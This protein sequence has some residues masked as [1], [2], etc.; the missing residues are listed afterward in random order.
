MTGSTPPPDRQP[1][2]IAAKRSAIGRAGGMFR[3]V[4]IEDLAAP[5]LRAVA[6]AAGIDAREIDDVILGNAAGP[7]GNVARL[8]SLQAGF[9]VDVPGVTMD[10]QCGAGLEA[11]ITACRLIAAGAGDVFVAG[12]VE[13]VSRAP[14]RALPPPAGQAPQFYKRARFSPDAIGDPDMGEAAETVART[15]GITRARQDAFA[16]QSQ[17]RAAAAREAGAFDAE[18]IAVA[19]QRRDECIR[20]DMTAARLARLRPAF[21]PGGTVTAGNA[22]PLNDGAC[23]VVVTSAARARALGHRRALAFLDAAAAGV[24]PSVLGIGPVASTRKLLARRPDLSLRDLAL[25]EFNEA[26]AAQVLASLDALDL[27]QTL[28]SQQGGAI[29]LGHPFGA[30]G[31]ILVT[32]L[33][34]QAMTGPDGAL[35]MA[36]IGIGGGQGLTAALSPMQ[37]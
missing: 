17:S 20:G 26:F 32:R 24:D 19:G 1:V 18:I 11:V 37:V 9:G 34:A 12:G 21:A 30:S 23:A 15:H 14:L 33:F 10:R 35:C 22:C 6:D 4:E 29:A 13:S 2:I 27:P 7:G 25:L 5:V 16:L 36:M 28:P 3:D 31:A 8:S